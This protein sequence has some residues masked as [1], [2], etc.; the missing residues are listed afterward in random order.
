M[1]M[2]CVRKREIITRDRQGCQRY[3]LEP[4]RRWWLSPSRRCRTCPTVCHR[5]PRARAPAPQSPLSG[6]RQRHT[7]RRPPCDLPPVDNARS[8]LAPLCGTGRAHWAMKGSE[9]GLACGACQIVSRSPRCLLKIGT[10][11]PHATRAR[12]VGPPRSGVRGI[13][14]LAVAVAVRHQRDG[15]SGSSGG[16]RGN[17]RSGR[18][19]ART[20]G[21]NLQ[22]AWHLGNLDRLGFRK[23]CRRQSRR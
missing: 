16:R 23:S 13:S 5:A 7:A 19:L 15:G 3:L 11:L 14:L 18:S 1:S 12:N 8:R 2:C 20:L 6:P 10:W 22:A 21:P 4:L 9:Q 17:L